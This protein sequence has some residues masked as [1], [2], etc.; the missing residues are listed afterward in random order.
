MTSPCVKLEKA[1][2]SPCRDRRF[3]LTSH[4]RLWALYRDG[5]TS[6]RLFLPLPVAPLNRLWVLAPI[7]R[8][9]SKPYLLPALSFPERTSHLTK[10]TLWRR[11]PLS[12]KS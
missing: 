6:S 10:I 1:G 7:F 12:L 11:V 4:L 9:C 2:R 8:L 3:A 5:D